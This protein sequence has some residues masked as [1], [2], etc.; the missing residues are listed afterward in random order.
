M[1]EAERNVPMTGIIVTL[2]IKHFLLGLTCK[3]KLGKCSL[4]NNDPLII[5]FKCSNYFNIAV[6]CRNEEF[7]LPKR[8]NM[9]IKYSL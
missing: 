1:F 2:L 6:I 3:E 4:T 5:L 8:N 9:A 7:F